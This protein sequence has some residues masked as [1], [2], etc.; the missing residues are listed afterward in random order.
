MNAFYL[1][2]AAY[3]HFWVAGIQHP[4]NP[5]SGTAWQLESFDPFAKNMIYLAAGIRDYGFSDQLFE[6]SVPL[7][8]NL[9]RIFVPYSTTLQ[10]SRLKRLAKM[11]KKRSIA[12]TFVGT[13]TSRVREWVSQLSGENALKHDPRVYLRFGEARQVRAASRSL[14]GGVT[15]N[16]SF[17]N[18]YASSD[19]CL[20]LAGH[21]HDLTKRCYD[22]MAQGCLPVIVTKY[23]FWMALPFPSHGGWKSFASFHRVETK[24]ELRSILF[25]LLKRHETDQLGIRWQREALARSPG[26]FASHD[27][28][29]CTEDER[30]AFRTNII[31]ELHARQRVWPHL[32]SSWLFEP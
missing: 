25:D 17:T 23:R 18:L 7:Y 9:Q 3:D 6:W 19:F 26:L 2:N 30:S 13:A 29:S 21:L 11:K 1:R 14:A 31:T 8:T 22:A 24:D 27:P 20:V 5:S 10:C 4:F 15:N 16:V 12:I 28:T 32:R